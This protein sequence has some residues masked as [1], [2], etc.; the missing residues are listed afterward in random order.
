MSPQDDGVKVKR[1]NHE[2]TKA[3][4]K[5]WKSVENKLWVFDIENQKIESRSLEATFAIDDYLYVPRLDGHL[6]DATKEWF[7]GAE[8]ELAVFFAETRKSRL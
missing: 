6:T 1:Q 5:R 2:V 3:L 8:N 7:S 4:L